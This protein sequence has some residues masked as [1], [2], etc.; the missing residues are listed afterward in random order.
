MLKD[1]TTVSHYHFGQSFCKLSIS[2]PITE[3]KTK[4]ALQLQSLYHCLSTKWGGRV[5]RVG[6]EDLPVAGRGAGGG[7]ASPEVPL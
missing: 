2:L 7:G 3:E 1:M 5:D 4:H 6:V